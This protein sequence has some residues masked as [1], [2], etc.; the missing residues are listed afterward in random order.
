LKWIAATIVDVSKAGSQRSE[1]TM[2]STDVKIQAAGLWMTPCH[3][4]S[5]AML[6][7]GGEF[8]DAEERCQSA[9]NAG[10]CWQNRHFTH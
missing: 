9:S 6:S 8:K 4:P 2:T 7:M 1:K 10:N 3:A 5:R